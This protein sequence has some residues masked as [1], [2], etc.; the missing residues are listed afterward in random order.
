MDS[1]QIKNIL[2]KDVVAK[3][4]FIGVLAR[5]KLPKKVDWP[6][7]LILNTD[8]SNKP[9]EHWLALYYDENGNCEFFDSF[10]FH[11]DFYNLTNYL[12]LTSKSFIYNKKTLQGI[13]SK[14]CGHYCI[15]FLLIRSR[16]FSLNYFLKFFE[17]NTEKND[18]LI[19]TLIKN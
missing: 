18:E 15:L 12:K 16:N 8:T 11:P 14:Y 4:Y 5:D 9:G 13:F 7:S 10:G 17:T 3:K 1:L 19:K 2:K 6:S